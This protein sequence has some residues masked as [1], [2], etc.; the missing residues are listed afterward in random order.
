[1]V[2][3]LELYLTIKWL[4][5]TM[6]DFWY[7]FLMSEKFSHRGFDRI[8]GLT[9]EMKQRADEVY[10]YVDHLLDERGGRFIEDF[11]V[12]KTEREKEIIHFVIAEADRVLRELGRKNPAEISESN[13]HVL[14]ED[15]TD[16]YTEGIGG[17]GAHATRLGSVL[18]DRQ[19]SEVKFA[20]VLFHELMHMKVCKALQLIRDDGSNDLDVYRSGLG[21]M[22]REAKN[23]YFKDFEEAVIGYLTQR[24]HNEVVMKSSLFEKEI[25]ESDG[26]QEVSRME[27]LESLN[28]LV[29]NL[30][31]QNKDTYESR[32][33]IFNLFVDAHVNGRLLKIGK[34]IEK[35]LGKGSFRQ[36][37][38]ETGDIGE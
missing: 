21:V 28:R 35:T 17:T 33:E 27:E 1:M 26:M 9:P 31:E 8:V 34:L 25:S 7:T 38:E 23:M 6:I 30:W 4:F 18:V 5:V 16:D 32:D 2:N 13:I 36:I 10:A 29:D 15:G 24:F 11:E 12:E 37:A 14:K 22:D 3:F 20:L 19:A